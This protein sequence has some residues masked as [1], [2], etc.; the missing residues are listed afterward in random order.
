MGNENIGLKMG[1]IDVAEIVQMTGGESI[2]VG[3]GYDGKVNIVSTDSSYTAKESLF[4]AIRGDKYDGH[5]FIGDALL[6]G[7]KII[8]AQRI[9]AEVPPY[10][11]Y[12]L[13]IVPDTVMALGTIAKHY[14]NRSHAKRIAVTGSV[15]KTT[16]KE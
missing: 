15:G 9:P 16:T 7:A 4:I 6:G 11:S 2:K 13:V 5:D 3:G 10:C 1:G 8:L 14:L 12:N